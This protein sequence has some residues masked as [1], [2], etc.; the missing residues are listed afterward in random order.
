MA[1]DDGAADLTVTLNQIRFGAEVPAGAAVLA[2]FIDPEPTCAAASL[3]PLPA[4]PALPL[5]DPLA[6]D[7]VVLCVPA[8]SPDEA[9]WRERGRAWL[10][11]A[12]D[13]SDP[14][15]RASGDGLAIAWRP[16][17]AV[18]SGPADRLEPALAALAEFAHFEGHLRR[19]EAEVAA[20][21]PTLESHTPLAHEVHG[22]DLKLR[23]ELAAGTARTMN[24]R[25]RCA[26][27]ERRLTAPAASLGESAATLGE[28]LR[29]E[30]DVA[31]RLETIDGQIE[32]YEYV[33]ELANQRMGEYRN[34]RREYLVEILIVALLAA[35]TLL[36]LAEWIIPASGD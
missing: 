16:G 12:D 2:T 34:F 24:R 35:E 15:V 14:P 21:W 33:Y 25:L 9:A 10:E 3:L 27:I 13:E 32:T 18:I 4:G 19:L 17:A 5:P 31:G 20:D 28:R 30:A 36:L 26:R 1:A 11:P 7:L 22:K 23:P 8:G 6:S 29:D